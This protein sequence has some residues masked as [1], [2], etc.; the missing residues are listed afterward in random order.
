MHFPSF[1]EMASD[2]PFG[3]LFAEI[4]DRH[5]AHVLVAGPVK[6]VF[7]DLQVL[8]IG[9]RNGIHIGVLRHRQMEPGIEHGDH[10][11]PRHDRFAGLDTRDV[12]GHMKR[13]QNGV[14]LADT[15]D[16]VV[17][18]DA[19][20]KVFA[21]VQNAVSDG[22]DLFDVGNDA[23][24]FVDERGKHALERFGM[25]HDRLLDFHLFFAHFFVTKIASFGVA[26]PFNEPLAEHLLFVHIDDLIF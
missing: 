20:G 19:F 1:A 14:F 22:G 17:N 24:L 9:I 12:R 10:R 21:G 16:F 5:A 3:I 8:V 2:D 6:T 15:N 18:H 13:S 11:R 26:D 23:V 7:T 4:I 25:V